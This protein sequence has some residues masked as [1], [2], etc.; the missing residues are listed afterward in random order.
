MGTFYRSILKLITTN[1][2]LSRKLTKLQTHILT[3]K[4]PMTTVARK[5]GIQDT[6]PTYMQSHMD[7]I[8]SPQSTLNTIMKECMK[9]VKF[10]RGNS[11]PGN[12]STWS[13]TSN[14]GLTLVSIRMIY[15]HHEEKNTSNYLEIC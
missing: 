11:P 15:T 9:S 10:H 1:D 3:T 8:H 6:S 5:N 12:R 14:F 2:Q 7:S 4:F 13:V